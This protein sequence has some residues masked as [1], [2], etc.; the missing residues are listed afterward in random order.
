MD[1]PLTLAAIGRRAESLFGDRPVV[2]RRADGSLHRSTWAE[3]LRRAH[4]LASALR[5]LGV[6]PGDR[7]ATL[8]WN[9]DRHLE[10][11]F[12]VPLLGAVLH[13]L[14][15]RLH[16]DEL[17]YI[18]RHAEDR[19]LIVDEALLPLLER[20]RSRAEFRHVIVIADGAARAGRHARL[21]AAARRGARGAARAARPRRARRRRDVLHLRHHR[22]LE[23]GR[24]LAPLARAPLDGHRHGRE[25][26]DQRGRHRARGHP[27]VSRQCLGSAV[28]GRAHRR[29]AGL[30]RASNSTQP[31][32]SSC[33]RRSASPSAP[34]CPPSGWA[35]S[36]GSMPARA[37]TTSARSAPS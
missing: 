33:A 3:S 37:R 15:L 28:H 34:A 16:P 10:A 5:G 21:R 6:G 24:L 36:S 27:H 23:G 20:F 4:R 13:T 7:V 9:H 25:L 30:S 26:R 14:N 1:Y 17:A 12:A 31:R 2:S 11:Y 18:A 29:E 32:C 19:V 22:P 8:C 35:C